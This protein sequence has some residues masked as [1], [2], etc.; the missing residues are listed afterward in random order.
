MVI[1]FQKWSVSGC[2]LN[3]KEILGNAFD[4]CS[5][6]LTAGLHATICRHALSAIIGAR[7]SYLFD[8]RFVVHSWQR[9][10]AIFVKSGG[11]FQRSQRVDQNFENWACVQSNENGGDQKRPTNRWKPAWQSWTKLLGQ[12]SR[13]RFQTSFSFAV[14]EIIVVDSRIVRLKRPGT[15]TVWIK[16][17]ARWYSV[18][19]SY[20][21]LNSVGVARS[22]LPDSR[23]AEINCMRKRVSQAFI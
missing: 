21:L 13:N 16:L 14:R 22:R 17:K 3:V 11:H 7:I 8:T 20:K 5:I 18:F 23:E 2:I 6:K 19:F 9:K 12:W 1:F 4:L 10:L 15:K